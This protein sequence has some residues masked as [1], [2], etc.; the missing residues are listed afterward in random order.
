MDL[1]RW[2]GSIIYVGKLES[3]EGFEI[4]HLN[5]RGTIYDNYLLTKESLIEYLKDASEIK[6]PASMEISNGIPDEARTTSRDI[7]IY[8][9]SAGEFLEIIASTNLEERITDGRVK[10]NYI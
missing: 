8:S 7:R 3:S 4:V 1:S 6:R 9:L 10:I 5:D 2:P